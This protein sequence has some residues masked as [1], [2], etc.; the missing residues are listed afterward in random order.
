MEKITDHA[1]RSEALLVSQFADS[2]KLHTLVR[3]FVEQLQAV[4]DAL[5]DLL[6]LRA[7]DT[8]IGAQ[9][10]GIG[11]IV[12]EPRYARNDFDYRAGL[13]FRIFVNTSTGTP[14]TIIRY[15]RAL[16]ESTEITYTEPDPAVVHLALNGAAITDDLIARIYDILPVAVGLQL[17]SI[18]SP[19][20]FSY[21]SEPQL[22]GR[23]VGI[24]VPTGGG[25]YGPVP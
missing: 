21:R 5:Y 17:E 4:E 20:Y 23:Y 8:A 10:D 24:G 16:N 6:V 11:S 12:G 19:N 15:V 14:D 2:E 9:L 7:L 13:R 1:A 25:I 22:G 3:I 18:D